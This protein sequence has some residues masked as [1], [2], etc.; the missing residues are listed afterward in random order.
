MKIIEDIV[1]VMPPPQQAA[2]TGSQ[3]AWA[4]ANARIGIRVPNDYAK[5]IDTYGSGEI[6]GFL[7][8]FNPFSANPNVQLAAQVA[9]VLSALRELKAQFPDKYRYPLH[10]EPGGFLPWGQS[11]DGDLYGW[12]TTGLQGHWRTL[13][14]PRHSPGAEEFPLSFGD[15][16]HG[17]LTGKVASLTLPPDFLANGVTFAAYEAAEQGDQPGN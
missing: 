17:I 9:V 6:N 12:L 5:L 1:A 4:A 2:E 16:L 3:Q 8:V 15:F 11:I 10:F 14:F 7:T 13:V